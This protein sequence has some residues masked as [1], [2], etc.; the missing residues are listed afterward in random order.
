MNLGV[1][2]I[3]FYCDIVKL[4][5]QVGREGKGKLKILIFAKSL[6]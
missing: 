1:G 4:M 2:C 6:N 5:A 3:L